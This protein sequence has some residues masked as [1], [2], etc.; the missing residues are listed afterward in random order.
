MAGAISGLLL[1]LD[2]KSAK[3]I[4]GALSG[5][6]GYLMTCFAQRTKI[7]PTA[8]IA[9][10]ISGMLTGTLFGMDYKSFLSSVLTGAITGY[11]CG[12]YN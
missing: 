5:V 2:S 10:A 6:A 4:G 9:A 8:L 11:I 12:N 1:V 7:E 3:A